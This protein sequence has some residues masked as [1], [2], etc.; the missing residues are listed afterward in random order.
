MIKE[1][2]SQLTV[3]H[4]GMHCARARLFAEMV[5]SMISN[6]KSQLK[7]LG[8]GVSGGAKLESKMRRIQMFFKE[9]E[10]G[11]E[12]F[13][14]LLLE[15]L[16]L[17]GPFKLAM[18]RT[19]WEFGKAK[20][21]YL[22]V[23][24]IF[25]NISIPL[26]WI[27][28]DKKGNSSTEERKNLMEKVLEIIPADKIEMLLGDREF[29]GK[30]W[31]DWLSKKK[32]HFIMR[33]KQNSIINGKSYVFQEF[34]ML[35]IG[36]IKTIHATLWETQYV[37]TGMKINTGELLIL[38]SNNFV[39]QETCVLYKQRWTIETLFKNLKT[40]GFNIEDTHMIDT[41]KLQKLMYIAALA[42]LITVKTGIL[43]N[44]QIPI[45]IKK[46]GRSLYSLFTYGLDF[47]RSVI[48]KKTQKSITKF[49]HSILNLSLTQLQT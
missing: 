5:I 48:L 38:A 7:S 12:E 17:E 9:Q 42:T 23:S 41:E 47:L 29:I 25:Q 8:I 2:L 36:E 46:H 40:R 19:N 14:M 37:I 32:I 31:F 28:L 26:C 20:I 30:V 34:N 33:I 16:G 4:I 44:M 18:D 13:G 27:V 43:R 24:I 45:L 6:G 11:S 10:I 49:I 15:V 21:N 1:T 22:M 35:K 39:G 3:K